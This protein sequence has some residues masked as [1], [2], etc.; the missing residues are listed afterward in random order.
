MNVFN[1]VD[2]NNNLSIHS[3]RRLSQRLLILFCSV[4]VCC[5]RQRF[6]CPHPLLWFVW[7]FIHACLLFS[8]CLAL[9]FKCFACWFINKVVSSGSIRWLMTPSS[10]SLRLKSLVWELCPQTAAASGKGK[11]ESVEVVAMKWPLLHVNSSEGEEFT[12]SKGQRSKVRPVASG[13]ILCCTCPGRMSYW[14]QCHLIIIVDLY[15]IVC[16][17][18]PGCAYRCVSVNEPLC[19]NL[20]DMGNTGN[21]MF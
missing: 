1:R 14:G 16:F 18:L 5:R 21:G 10:N 7:V 4:S 11:E 6:S 19:L 20:N 8:G 12:C 13:L 3:S 2:V 17:C 9:Y 15:G